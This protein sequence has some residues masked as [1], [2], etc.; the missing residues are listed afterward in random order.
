MYIVQF[1]RSFCMFEIF[2]NKFGEGSSHHDSSEMNL[3]SIPEDA[4]SFPGLA[5]WVKDPVLP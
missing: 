4:G 1:F 5:Q 2:H 3:P